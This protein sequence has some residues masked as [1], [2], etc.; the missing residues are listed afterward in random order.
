MLAAQKVGD[1]FSNSV[2]INIDLPGHQQHATLSRDDIIQAMQGVNASGGLKVKFPDISVMVNPDGET[3]QA[4]VTVEAQ[5]PSEQDMIV[6]EM[7]FTLRKIDG[8]WLITRVQTVRTL[9]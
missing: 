2:E 4:D 6:Q 8:K 9:S 1:F 3:A 5:A 7:K